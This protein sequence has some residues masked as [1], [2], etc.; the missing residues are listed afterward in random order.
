MKTKGPFRVW[1]M[2]CEI[3]FDTRD[4]HIWR[5]SD[6]TEFKTCNL[7]TTHSGGS[8]SCWRCIMQW[9]VSAWPNWTHHHRLLWLGMTLHNGYR[10]EM[11][12]SD[13]SR[14]SWLS[15]G[16]NRGVRTEVFLHKAGKCQR[17]TREF[18]RRWKLIWRLTS[19][20]FNSPRGQ[21]STSFLQIRCDRLN[22]G[23]EKKKK[24]GGKEDFCVLADFFALTL[25]SEITETKGEREEGE[26]LPL[27]RG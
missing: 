20:T 13:I 6:A 25:C 17:R 7:A 9:E 21:T 15:E 1:K 5:W 4:T 14:T 23:G 19:G 26:A 27:L 8:Q 22:A 24:N 16:R 10:G 12:N 3:V 18:I 2:W 11:E